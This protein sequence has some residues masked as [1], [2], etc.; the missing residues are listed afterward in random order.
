MGI[1]AP[2]M[3]VNSYGYRRILEYEDKVADYEE[4]FVAAVLGRGAVFSKE[5][6][7]RYLWEMTLPINAFAEKILNQ[8]LNI[9]YV[10]I[11]SV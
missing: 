6:I 8:V 11:N 2:L 4:R 5:N 3:V 9:P 10:S 7:A 1:L